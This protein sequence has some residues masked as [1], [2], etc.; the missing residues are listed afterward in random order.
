MKHTYTVT[1]MTCT[2]CHAKVTAI[3]KQ[4]PHVT[5]V[6]VD[7]DND[8]VTVSMDEYIPTATLQKTF[9][10]YPKY[11]LKETETPQK[12]VFV[13]DNK[14]ESK[15][16]VQTYKPI[17]I[18][19]GYIILVSVIV[20][21]KDTNFDSMLFMRTFMAGFF[22]TFSFFKMLDLKGFANSYAMYDIVAGKFKSWGYIYAFTELALVLLSL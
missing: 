17:F 11:T 6:A 20:A 1:G 13:D 21:A 2:G 10:E 5:N 19:A 4:I 15:S 7:A 12:N 16:W 14:L 3:I 22:F 9:K 18:I 8:T